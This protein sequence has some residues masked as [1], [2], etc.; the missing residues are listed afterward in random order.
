LL[1]RHWVREARI[2]MSPLT[3]PSEHTR[4]CTSRW[5]ALTCQRCRMFKNEILSGF[6]GAMFVSTTGVDG[7]SLLLRS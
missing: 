1:S 5:R 4:P 6:D 3:L 2:G 7:R